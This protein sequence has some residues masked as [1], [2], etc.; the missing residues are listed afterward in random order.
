MAEAVSQAGNLS[1]VSFADEISVRNIAPLRL[2]QVVE[3]GAPEAG[4]FEAK[5][6][7]EFED[8]IR[9]ERVKEEKEDQSP[10]EDNVDEN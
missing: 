5:V 9:E 2:E 1:G 3:P 4:P 7:G 8:Q 10:F 6:V